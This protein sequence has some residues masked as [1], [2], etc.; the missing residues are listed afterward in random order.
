MF[1]REIQAR[2]FQKLNAL[3]AAVRV[4]DLRLPPSNRLERLKGDAYQGLKPDGKPGW[5]VKR[6]GKTY[7]VSE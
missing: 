5:F 4:D 6:D 7:L 3:G 2:A 1:P